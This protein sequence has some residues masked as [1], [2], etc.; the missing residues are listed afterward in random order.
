MLWHVD[1]SEVAA[2]LREDV[3][4]P[5]KPDSSTEVFTDVD[6]GM[7]LPTWHCTFHNCKACSAD[8][9]DG[10]PHE[11]GLWQHITGNAG[12]QQTLVRIAEAHALFESHLDK[13]HVLF[14]LYAGAVAEK[15]RTFMPLLGTST[16]RRSLQQV[17]EVFNEGT[18]SVL[19]CFIVLASTSDTRATT[20][21]A[22]LK[23]R[24]ASPS[25]AV[26]HS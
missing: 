19:M 24:E 15:A 22:T 20:F 10:Y 21:S 8:I 13:E 18:T 14:S 2:L 11:Y 3:T 12:H 1:L 23:K 6:S 5:L 17:A 25:S 26:R 16:D 9:S 4:L 7:A